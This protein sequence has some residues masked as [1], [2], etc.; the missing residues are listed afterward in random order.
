MLMLPTLDPITKACGWPLLG[1]EVRGLPRQQEQSTDGG[2]ESLLTRVF[3]K[4]FWRS[5][6]SSSESLN[7]ANLNTPY[8]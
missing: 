8:R 7:D 3:R 5:A 2:K 4:A 1:R 6:R